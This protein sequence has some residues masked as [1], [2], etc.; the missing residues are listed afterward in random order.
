MAG[1][2]AVGPVSRRRLMA[3]AAAVLAAGAAAAC[4]GPGRRD[5]AKGSGAPHMTGA[6]PHLTAAVGLVDSLLGIG[7]DA[8]RN[9][10]KKVHEDDGRVT[11]VQWEGRPEVLAQCGSFQALVLEHAYGPG[12]DGGWATGAFFRDRFFSGRG[13]RDTRK[14]FPNAAEFRAGFA[15]G[16]GAPYFER[17]AG[18]KAL[19]PGDLVA[20]DYR[21]AGLW[22]SGH[23]VMVR[24]ARG[25]LA[26]PVDEQVGRDAVG[27]VFE[28]VD[29]T[30][31]PHGDPERG[32]RALYERYPD[33][34][35]TYRG[36][37]DS[38]SH[39]HRHTGAGFGHMVLYADAAGGFAGYRWSVNSSRASTAAHRPL[40]AARVRAAG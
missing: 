34:R 12:T 11:R 26:S 7:W 21:D 28:V 37:R 8:G 23:I 3:G 35:L 14:R 16:A 29:C 31:S 39:V 6:P 9:A 32:T 13:L 4:S 18:P 33:T 5:D 17:V 10:Y 22:Y 15:A 2:S 1:R 20:I 30:D 40:A 38:V 36:D 19:R 25:V 27:H 24:A